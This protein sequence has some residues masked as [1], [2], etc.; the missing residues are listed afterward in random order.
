LSLYSALYAGVSGLSAEASAMAGV[1]DNITNINTIGYKGIDTQFSTLV[2]DGAIKGKYSA[3]GLTAVPQALISKQGLLQASSSATDLGIDGPGF[4]VTRQ[5]SSAGS[6]VTFTRAGSFKPD[7]DGYLRN[8]AGLYLQGWPLN[9]QGGYSNTG[10]VTSLQPVRLSNLTGTAASTSK[11]AVRA[12]LDSTATA[13]TGTYAAGDMAAG[14]VTPQFTRS[15]EVYDAQGNAHTMAMGFLKTGANQWKGEIYAQPAGD[16][17]ATG[18]LLASGTIAFNPDGSLNLAGSTPAFFGSITPTWTNA[19]GSQAIQLGL[20]SNGGL[21][22]LTQFGNPS[23]VISRSVDGGKLGN[24]ASIDIS[25]S[26]KVSAVFDDGTS[27]AVYQ[28]PIATFP[29]PDGLSRITGNAYNM[30]DASGN[31][32]I[33]PPGSLGAGKISAST[34]E[35]SNV[36]LAQEFTNMIRFQRAY[37]ASSK[38]ITTVDE[39]LQEV[40]NLKR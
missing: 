15:F 12:N 39:M 33:N 9:A 38:I 35:A 20:G 26:G 32:A 19:A 25:E 10:S 27:R 5:G 21:D 14:T 8:Q 1:A 24:I 29:N 31:V 3:G 37:S 22:G 30:S 40:S 28:L 36:D 18:G 6:A 17:T 4:F 11:I 7:E 16:V 2:T 23:A 13:F 34:L